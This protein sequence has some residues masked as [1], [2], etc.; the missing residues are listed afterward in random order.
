MFSL[1]EWFRNSFLSL[2]RW[3][4]CKLNVFSFSAKPSLESGYYA[5][6]LSVRVFTRKKICRRRRKKNWRYIKRKWKRKEYNREGRIGEL[7]WKVVGKNTKKKR[8][9]NKSRKRGSWR[10]I[11]RL[12]KQYLK[13]HPTSVSHENAITS[14]EKW[15]RK[16]KPRIVLH[17]QS[18]PLFF[19]WI[20]I[21][22]HI[23]ILTSMYCVGFNVHSLFS[24]AFIVVY[25][26]EYLK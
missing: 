7:R 25:L 2:V 18:T 21:C 12:Y 4:L 8:S 15:F 26:Q 13:R 20:L 3:H 22:A 1:R 23:H 19:F 11:V 14:K 6:I 16:T 9:W 10:S 5:N 24:C 17:K